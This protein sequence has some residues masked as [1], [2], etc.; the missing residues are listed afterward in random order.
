[1]I[2][3]LCKIECC[4]NC[5]SIFESNGI[6]MKSLFILFVVLIFSTQLYANNKFPNQETIS[7]LPKDGGNRYN[8]LVFEKSPYLLQHC[9]NPVDWYPWGPEAFAKAKK[10]NKPIFLSIGYSSCHWCHVME[11]DSFEKEEVA[12]VLNQSYVAI[13]VD[14]EERPDIDSVYMSATQIIKRGHG[15]WPNSLWL[16]ADKQPWYAATYLPRS[17]FITTLKQLA[18]VYKDQKIEVQKQADQISK[19]IKSLSNQNIVKT[20]PTLAPKKKL[21]A[22]LPNHFDRFNAKDTAGPK[23]P[24]HKLIEY[25]LSSEFI[26]K[27]PKLLSSIENLMTTM[28]MGGIHDQIGGGFSRYSTDGKWLLPH[29]EKMLYDNAQLAY[30]YTL[31]YQ[32]TKNDFYKQ[33]AIEIFEFIKRDMSQKGGGFF[34]AFDADSEGEEGKFYLFTTKELYSELSKEDAI[35]FIKTYNLKDKGNYTSETGETSDNNIP[36]LSKPQI[37]TA[38]QTRML[39]KLR[40]YREK[41]EWPLLDDKILVSWNGL[42]I[43]AFALASK[44]FHKKEYMSFALQSISFINEKMIIKNKLYHSSRLSQVKSK[45]FLSDYAY[46]VQAL[47]EVHKITLDSKILSFASHLTDQAKTL[48]TNGNDGYYFTSVDHEKLLSKELAESDNVTPSS[49]A[50]FLQNIIYIAQ[51]KKDKVAL[52]SALQGLSFYF[53]FANRNPMT[54]ASMI[55]AYDHYL[56]ANTGIKPKKKQNKWLP[57]IVKVHKFPVTVTGVYSNDVAT[58]SVEIEEGWH[59]NSNEP[60][61]DYLIPTSITNASKNIVKVGTFQY[62]ESEIIE[63][64]FAEEEIDVFDGTFHLKLPISFQKNKQSFQLKFN[65]QACSDEECMSPESMLLEF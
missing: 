40:Q 9:K 52:A 50:I 49:A 12:K 42:M 34:S 63:M 33:T 3:N 61:Q 38:H 30:N 36:F 55:Q 57:K 28:A 16:N 14:K 64:E 8:R 27:E 21:I 39:T 51:Q 26:K 17:E 4:T 20:Q 31:L 60:L 10:E 1:M 35:G 24:P 29:F 58:L 5:L 25:S 11:K 53:S 18:K 22:K 62:P 47:L 6:R 54:S 43:R 37:K 44:V 65:T 23:F 19:H 56:A 13:K 41:R 48:F 15:G 45:A 32:L 46:Y 7:K 2:I 59:I